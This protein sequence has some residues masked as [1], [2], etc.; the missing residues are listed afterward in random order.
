MLAMTVNSL[1]VEPEP[2]TLAGLGGAAA[3][4]ADQLGER[5]LAA[6]GEPRT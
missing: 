3:E 4:A 6:R 5:L 1:G 2:S